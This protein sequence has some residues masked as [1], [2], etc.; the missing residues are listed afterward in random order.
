MID[1]AN[2]GVQQVGLDFFISV[3]DD[4]LDIVEDYQARNPAIKIEK[5]G[6]GYHNQGWYYTEFKLADEEAAAY[7]E[8]YSHHVAHL[9]RIQGRG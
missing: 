7:L 8:G 4:A 3:P 1:R 2:L 5:V 6:H 9:R